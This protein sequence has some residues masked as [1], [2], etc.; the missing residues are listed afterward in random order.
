MDRINTQ[1][2][3]PGDGMAHGALFCLRSNHGDVM[4]LDKGK[5]ESFNPFRVD[6]VIIS[7]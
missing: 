5:I 1:G 4:F 7:Q 2:V 3:E 6:A